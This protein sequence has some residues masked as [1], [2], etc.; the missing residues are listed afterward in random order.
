MFKTQTK[1]LP[2][3]KKKWRKH[4]LS[5]QDDSNSVTTGSQ[6]NP[7]LCTC[8]ELWP[9]VELYYN[10]STST[11][12]TT[13]EISGGDLTHQWSRCL[14][15]YRHWAETRSLGQNAATAPQPEQRTPSTERRQDTQ[16]NNEIHYMRNKEGKKT[17]KCKTSGFE[18]CT[19]QTHCTVCTQALIATKPWLIPTVFPDQP[20]LMIL[21]TQSG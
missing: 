3:K 15:P 18:S 17:D 8:T 13:V 9:L 4:N 7:Y 10:Y 21:S 2:Y 11:L 16:K 6:H 12:L 20:P 1:A 14:E 19:V 5:S